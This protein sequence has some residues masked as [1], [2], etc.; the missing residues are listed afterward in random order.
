[1]SNQE[2]FPEKDE[3]SLDKVVKD[4]LGNFFK[5]NQGLM[6]TFRAINNRI[7][8]IIIDPDE[9]GYAKKNLQEIL[10]RMG[11]LGIIDITT[12]SG[13]TH[14]LINK[15]EKMDLGTR[16]KTVFWEQKIKLEKNLEEKLSNFLKEN[17]GLAFTIGDLNSKLKEIIKD[18]DKVDFAKENLQDILNKMKINGK[19]DIILSNERTYYIIKKSETII[20]EKQEEP[21]QAKIFEMK[22]T[23]P[24]RIAPIKG[25]ID[26]S[27][28][29]VTKV[30]L[31][32]GV[33]LGLLTMVVGFLFELLTVLGII[34]I[35][36]SI[37]GEIVVA[38]KQ[39]RE[40]IKY[41]RPTYGIAALVFD[42]IGL[43]LLNAF[44]FGYSYYYGGSSSL[45]TIPFF[46]IA[47]LC[48]VVGFYGG[49]DSRPYAAIVGL[50]FGM[51]FFIMSLFPLIYY[52]VGFAAILYH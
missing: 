2:T 1:M 33:I 17:R 44:G 52:L 48:G 51:T 32:I 3:L 15:V 13:E 8:D 22:R 10:D 43:I 12:H 24:S 38:S 25:Y 41:D 5:E 18:S 26:D 6:F 20:Q 42:I 50:F 7:E 21:V 49:K 31:A 28:T 45:Y 37:L 39:T 27:R 14:Y 29:Q 40:N 30:I 36:L 19:I 47:I 4:K 46:I 23:R 35:I 34:F 11:L 9:L 16:S